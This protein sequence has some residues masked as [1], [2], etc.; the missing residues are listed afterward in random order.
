MDFKNSWDELH[1]QPQFRPKYPDDRVVAWTF[2]NFPRKA[3]KQIQILDVG[4][5]AGRHSIFLATE[6]YKP[7]ACDFSKVGVEE[8]ERRFREA[9]L[10]VTAAVCE[11]DELAFPDESFD[12]A[13]VY[14][15]YTYLPYERFVQ[16]VSELRRVLK[17]G[18]KA[19]VMTRTTRDSRVQHAEKLGRSTYRIGSIGGGVPA[20]YQVET[21]MIMTFLDEKEARDMFAD[22]SKVLVDRMTMTTSGG[23]FANDDW[24]IHVEK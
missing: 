4:C 18:G 11:A 22:F 8:T 1:K 13:L 9:G 7:S 12:G 16:A 6:G 14:G 3:G 10:T 19:L 20:S 5:G 15:T 2:R 17:P 23:I 24:Y 21:G